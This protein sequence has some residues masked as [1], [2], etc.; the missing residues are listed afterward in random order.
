MAQTAREKA[1]A[2]LDLNERRLARLKKQHEK[3]ADVATRTKAELDATVKERDYLASHPALKDVEALD[4]SVLDPTP[5]PEQPPVET[6][7][8]PLQF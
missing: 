6:G 7:S 4:E 8:D 2:A 1:Q 5:E 3:A